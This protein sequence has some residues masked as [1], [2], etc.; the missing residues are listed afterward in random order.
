MSLEHIRTRVQEAWF[1]VNERSVAGVREIET[2]PPS[3]IILRGGVHCK[4]QRRHVLR[5]HNRRQRK[6]LDVRYFCSGTDGAQLVQWRSLCLPK[7]SCTMLH[8]AGLRYL[9]TTFLINTPAERIGPSVSEHTT[10]RNNPAKDG[11]PQNSPNKYL[12]DLFSKPLPFL[13]QPLPSM[14]FLPQLFVA[15]VVCSELD[16]GQR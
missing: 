10:L 11:L 7:I 5:L 9:I 12:C 15:V 16:V 8:R 2:F 13:D 1:G 4:M 6:E 3:E 14:Y